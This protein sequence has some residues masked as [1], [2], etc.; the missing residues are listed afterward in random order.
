MSGT[1][2]ARDVRLVAH[3]ALEARAFA[4][5]EVQAEAHRVG[6][7]QDVGEQDGGVERKA[8]E[9]LQRHFGGVVGVRREAHEAAGAGA[10]GV[11]LGQV[12]AGLAHQ[13]DRRVVGGLAQ[14]R[15]QEG[16]VEKGMGHV[17]RC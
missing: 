2:Q 13:P 14:E 4:L 12:A 7:G 16:V 11:V 1:R 3:R 6:H 15:A 17:A 9:R 5:D 10:R 8:L